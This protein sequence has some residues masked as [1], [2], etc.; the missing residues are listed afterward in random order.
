MFFYSSRNQ[1]CGLI[2]YITYIYHVYQSHQP[3]NKIMVE[4]YLK[5]H[6]INITDLSLVPV[7]TI[8]SYT[9][10]NYMVFELFPLQ[11]QTI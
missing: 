1:P 11:H 6:L 9:N 2:H 8:N 7:Y 10:Y 5:I 4:L 3:L